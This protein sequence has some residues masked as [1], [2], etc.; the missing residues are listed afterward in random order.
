MSPAPKWRNG[1]RDGLKHRWGQ[2]RPGSNPGFGTKPIY[3]LSTTNH[4]FTTAHIAASVPNHL[5]SVPCCPT[6]PAE[7]MKQSRA[8]VVP[9][10]IQALAVLEEAKGLAGDSPYVFAGAHMGKHISDNTFGKLARQLA[11][12]CNP[13]GF[14]SSFRDW[15]GSNQ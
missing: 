10:S 11:L 9:L 12:G 14:R 8:H 15:A 7:R 3:P 6:I 5:D 2:P 13:H 1:R 4:P